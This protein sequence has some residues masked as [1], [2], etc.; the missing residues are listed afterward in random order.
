MNASTEVA[1]LL[2][3][4]GNMAEQSLVG[5]E[6]AKADGLKVVGIYCIFAPVEIIRAAGALPVGL[7]GKRAEPIAAADGRLPPGSHG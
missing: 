5:L 4:F 7:C 3:S 2:K 6:M 1:C